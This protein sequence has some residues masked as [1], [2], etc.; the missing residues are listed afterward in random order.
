MQS[1]I[2]QNLNKYRAVGHVSILYRPK[3]YF[4]YQPNNVNIH[5]LLAITIVHSRSPGSR[6]F[7][8]TFQ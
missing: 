7:V 3:Q 8:N 2:I 1:A 6:Y 5:P 4:P